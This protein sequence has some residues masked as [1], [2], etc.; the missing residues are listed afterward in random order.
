[1]SRNGADRMRPGHHPV[2]AADDDHRMVAGPP[3]V[4]SVAAH[5]SSGTAGR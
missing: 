4:G 3:P 5:A 2:A 1:M